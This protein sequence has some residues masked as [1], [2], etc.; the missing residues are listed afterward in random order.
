MTERRGAH[1]VQRRASARDTIRQA[2]SSMKPSSKYFS[3]RLILASISL[4][5]AL[6]RKSDALAAADIYEVGAARVDVTPPYPIRLNGFGFRRDESVGVTQRI[7]AKAIAIGSNESK[8]VVLITLDSLGIRESMVDEV[9]RRLKEK[10]G[11]ERDRVVVVFTHSHTTPVVD[12]AADT[13]FSADI[14]EEHQ[15]HIERYTRELTD[16]LEK[17]ALDALADRKPSKLFWGI[18]KVGF[19]KNRRLV[20]GPVDHALPVLV[21]KSAE[22][23]ALCAIYTTYACHCVTLS[24]NKISGDWAGFAQEAIER[25]HPGIVGLVSVGCGSDSNPS[26]GVTGDNTAV[27]AEQGAQIADEVDRLLA[28]SL[29]PVSGPIVATLQ[30]LDL[31]LNEVPSREALEQAAT[32]EG[33]DAYNAK[34]Q[35]KKLDRGEALI[36][37][38]DYPVQSWAFGDSLAM[39]FLGGEVCVDYSLRLKEELDP[40]RLWMHGYANDFCGYIPSERLL[41]EGGYG[42]GAESGYFALPAAVAPGLEEK[43]IAEVHRQVPKQ[44]VGKGPRQQ[45]STHPLPLGESLGSIHTKDDFVV[46]VAA[47]E[48]LVNDPVA[49]DFGPD[50]RLWVAEMPDYTRYPEEKFDPHGS[51]RVLTDTDGDGRFDEATEFASNLQFPTDVKAWRRG[52]IVCDAP[53]V[54]YLEDTDGDGKADLRKILLT[55]FETHNAQ[56]RVNSLRWGLDNWLYG[57]CGVFGGTITNAQGQVFKLGGRDFRF[58]PDTG[59]FEPATGNTQQGRACDDWGNWFGCSSGTIACHYPLIDK[60]LVRN[61]LV[62]PPAAAVYLPSG[63]NPNQLF[64]IGEPTLYKLSGPPGVPTSIC[65]LDIYRDELLG[66]EFANN[67]FVAE[68]VNQLVHRLVL[69][70][71]GATFTGARAKGEEA[72]EFLAST[73]SWFRPVQLRT[74]LDGCLYVVDMHRAVI[75]HPRFIPQ[76]DVAK[77][78]LMAGR[79]QGRIYRVRPRNAPARAPLRL[80]QLEPTD[81]AAAIDSPNGPQRDLAQELLVAQQA[82]E[83]VPALEQL[84]READRP[85]TRLQALCTLEG[86]NSLSVATIQVALADEHPAVRRHA[87]RV[88]ELLLPTTPALADAVL[89]L[90]DDSDAQVRVQLAHSL[91]GIADPRATALLATLAR[92][93]ATD[94]Y[95]L[96]AVWSSVNRENVGDVVAS[97]LKAGENELP[98]TVLEPAVRLVLGLGGPQDVA[99]VV[100]SLSVVA[101]EGPSSQQL[102]VAGQLLA[103]MRGKQH[104]AEADVEQFSPLLKAAWEL[105][106]D[107]SS[108]TPKRLLALRLIVLSGDSPKKAISLLSPLL[109]PQ[110]SPEVRQSAIELI[111]TVED[112]QASEALLEAWRGFTTASRATTFDVLL[113]DPQSTRLLLQKVGKGS[114]ELSDFDAMQRQRL[115][116]HADEAIRAEAVEMLAGAIDPNREAMVREYVAAANGTG[117]ATRGQQVFS[118]HCTSCHQLQGEG[119]K[120]G[121]DLAAVTTRSPLALIESILDPN[122]AVEERYRSYSALTLNGL[123]HTGILHDETSTSVTLL[124]QQGKQQT[125][126]RSDI[127]VLETA[128]KSLMPEGLERDVTKEDMNDLLAYLGTFSP[129]PKQIAGNAPTTV[130]AEDDGSLCLMAADAEIYGDQ[131]AFATQFGNLESW[132]AKADHVVWKAKLTQGGD[133]DVY[134]ESSAPDDCEGNG[135]AIDGGAKQLVGVV[136]STGGGDKYQTALVGT[137]T[138]ASGDN[139][140]AVRPI[141]MR[142]NHGL[143]N[144]RAFYL[145]PAGTSAEALIAKRSLQASPNAADTIAKLIEGLAVGTPKE[146]E[147]ISDIWTNALAAGKR[148]DDAELTALLEISIP[149]LDKPLAHWQAVVIGGGVIN[150]WSQTGEWPRRRMSSLL[151][152]NIWLKARWNRALL[153][154]KSMADDTNVPSG[155]RY[156]ALRMLGA[157]SW[158]RNETQL[159]SYLAADAHVELQMGAVSALSDVEEPA[160]AKALIAALDELSAPNVR[161]AVAAM[162]RTNERAMTLANALDSGTVSRELLSKEEISLMSKKLSEVSK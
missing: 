137:I 72:A 35:L 64:P 119:H 43:I 52:V 88:S 103:H 4:F 108:D 47:A 125:L 42:G 57:A 27:A 156:D 149:Q 39:V 148:N 118:K 7:W 160:A 133:F 13:L 138:L 8:P 76:E 56:A 20:D 142:E 69:T 162:L 59:E 66:S 1:V 131:I 28:G 78:D 73:D 130:S 25:T 19:A 159:V 83:A 112:A 129:T 97:L 122:R 144:L 3:I 68:P 30:H 36:T 75:E 147:R 5:A 18:G 58:R 151:A 86:L 114:I 157:D 82:I 46:E 95:L 10:A 21:V 128:G 136:K 40:K 51:V 22:D 48:P 9:A 23:D 87:I 96:A 152:D 140:I 38:L 80:D 120:V 110:Q 79:E 26:S 70:G 132:H 135:Y 145:V 150:G 11:I 41:K 12:G 89:A 53:D 15:A 106:G 17:S 60:Y 127:D 74:G 111:A 63:P 98:A 92:S 85:A 90:S 24:N 161:I 99:A 32:G 105:A 50:G 154:A 49:I 124:E 109:A 77:M 153:L 6:S 2:Y 115:L 33:G 141:S 31:P 84:V 55:G 143:M 100:E 126:L 81:L 54:I 107:D 91:A 155:T 62:V 139:R 113:R 93:H 34:Y 121:P 61:P 102:A 16:A 104:G 65:G 123:A 134:L 158:N 101:Q 14:P 44:F 94:Q 45:A 71:Q 29:E 146:Y 37:K 116:T 67:L 117:D